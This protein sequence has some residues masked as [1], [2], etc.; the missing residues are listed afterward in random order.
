M[1]AYVKF[2]WCLK[3]KKKKRIIF[4]QTVLK[5]SIAFKWDKTH[6]AQRHETGRFA[7]MVILYSLSLNMVY[8]VQS[9]IYNITIGR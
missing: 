1:L 8:F 3:K 2:K 5:N 4:T 7:L 6:R 9:L